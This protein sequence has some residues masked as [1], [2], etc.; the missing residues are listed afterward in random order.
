MTNEPRIHD[1]QY[2]LPVD[3]FEFTQ[4]D[5]KLRDK[6]LETKPI[7]YLKDAYLRFKKNKASV[8][9][10]VIIM[11]LLLYAIIAPIFSSFQVSFRE[12]VYQKMV[13]KTHYLSKLGIW[14]GSVSKTLNQISYDYY[15]G[16]QEETGI[17]TILKVYEKRE[18]AANGGRSKQKEK[19]YDISL[20]SYAAVGIVYKNMTEE[21]FNRLCKWQDATGIQVLYPQLDLSKQEAG[22]PRTLLEDANIWYKI[23]PRGEAQR[24]PAGKLQPI[25]L[26][27][28][29]DQYK[30]KRVPFDEGNLAYFQ[31]NQNGFSVRVLYSNYYRYLYSGSEISPDLNSKEK[32]VYLVA[33]E[34]AFYFGTNQY[35]QDIF[36][37]LASGA[38]FSF[39][40][41]ILISIINL[42]IGAVVG[43]LEGYYGGWFDIVMERFIEVLSG[44]P[45]MITAT[46]FQLHL[47]RK[48]G[49]AASLLFAFVL[50]GWVGMSSLTRTQFYR[51]KHQ[52][53]VLAARTLG[54]SDSR[55]IRKHIFP[56][57]IGTIIT[58]VVLIIP[59]VI[60]S[61]SILSYLGIVNL[62]GSN[63]TSVGTLLAG[64]QA[65]LQDYPHIIF[66]PA[67][68][69]A[70]L[71]ISFNL[72]GNGLRDAFNP[73]MRG[74]DS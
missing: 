64:G 49:P 60:F 1:N 72:F 41:A 10:F 70:L 27:S 66:F 32:D 45:F 57:A 48:V 16:I 9:A 8:A 36:A 35:G 65:Y 56:N 42:S 51:F 24:N 37:C 17:P 59:G 28:S 55:I 25:Y 15:S 62:S 7:S 54:A 29:S 13:P 30:S 5:V 22:V 71:Q 6:E 20:D 14:D 2:N 46:L 11:I 68:F 4:Q 50:T 44:V 33:R 61:E 31:R 39:I 67:V 74:A 18:V 63:T 53:Y 58:S 73:S 69:I 40:L 3:A 38:R 21:D 12:P 23:T 52:E 43:A 34:P 19:Y 26:K 47:A